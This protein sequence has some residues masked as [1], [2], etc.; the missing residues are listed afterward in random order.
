MYDR[1]Q[2]VDLILMFLQLA[3]S[4]LDEGRFSDEEQATFWQAAAAQLAPWVVM[5][6]APVFQE[7]REWRLVNVDAR[8]DLEFRRFGHRIV[9]YVRVPLSHESITK[10]VRGPHFRDTDTHSAY[11][12]LVSNGFVTGTDVHDSKIPLRK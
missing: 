6:K 1:D 12:M 4:N 8:S 10:V 3:S 7:E 5:F 11:L 2:Q 9:P